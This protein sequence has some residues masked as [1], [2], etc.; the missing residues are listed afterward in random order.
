M[1]TS[2]DPTG[3]RVLGMINNCAGGVTPWGTW[4]T[5]EENIH[6]YFNGRPA[7]R[8]SRGAQLP[9]LWACRRLPV[10]T[11][12]ARSTTASI[13]PRSRTSP[14]VS[15]GWS[16]SIRSIRPRRRRSARRSAASSTK[17]PPAS[18]IRTAA[19]WSIAATTS[20]STMSIA[21][22]PMRASTAPILRA[23][24]DILDD[25]VLSVARYNA[26]GTVDWLP[27]VH[28]QGPLTAQNGFASQA[29]V[30]IETRT[31]RRLPRRHADGPPGG[32]RGQPGDAEGLCH[33]HQQPRPRAGGRCRQ[34]ARRQSLR[35]YHRDDPARRR[36]RG[37]AVQWEIL[38]KCG[39]PAIA[40][41]GA[42]FSSATTSNGWFGMPDNIAFDSQGRMWIA[43]DGT[44]EEHHRPY[45]RI[46]GRR[47]RRRGAR[48][49]EALLSR[50]VGR[51]TV[52]AVLH[53]R[54]RDAVR[55]RAASGE[56]ES[57][58]RA[59]ELRG[60]VDALAGF[61]ARRCR[62]GRRSSPSPSAAAARSRRSAPG[63]RAGQTG[64]SPLIVTRRPERVCG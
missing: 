53:A 64:R 14:T 26:D 36:S 54:R 11:P 23:N 16:R 32:R 13:S 18:S 43:T 46:V 41:V 19:T 34:P 8:A 55:R 10:D 2:A 56:E 45:R 52:R 21:S 22:S 49:L 47:D 59:L 29:D 40:A 15:A 62:R 5:C 61:Q 6:G 30:L 50:A 4:L 39:N 12:G 17:A 9:A 37:G 42:A 51:R 31:R 25:G 27:L 3:R 7:R 33:P 24:R 63:V 1:Q 57:V 60:A 38:V 28:G 35:P 48:H 44:G 20:A 58:R